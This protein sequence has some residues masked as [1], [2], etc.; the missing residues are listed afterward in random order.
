MKVADQS[1]TLDRVASAV[2]RSQWHGEPRA[3]AQRA[4]LL[5]RPGGRPVARGNLAERLNIEVKT[6]I[7]LRGP[8]ALHLSQTEAEGVITRQVDR[9][10]SSGRG[11]LDTG[12]SGLLAMGA[13]HLRSNGASPQPAKS[14]SLWLGLVM[15]A[16]AGA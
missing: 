1:K 2:A 8:R 5:G 3:L 9:A 16:P 4:R 12:Y 7:A 14:C 11:Q 6:P 10:A 13:F 15:R